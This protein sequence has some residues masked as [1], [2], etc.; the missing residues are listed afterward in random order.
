MM[1]P[2]DDKDRPP[3]TAFILT[4]FLSRGYDSLSAEE[5]A[6]T[7]INPDFN[8]AF[9]RQTGMDW[10]SKYQIQTIDRLKNLNFDLHF[11][12]SSVVLVD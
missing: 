4:K 11:M 8:G 6:V 10:I 1:D 5:L 12:T 9:K 7:L 2:V 3:D